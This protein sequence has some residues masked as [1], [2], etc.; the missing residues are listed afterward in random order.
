MKR[1]FLRFL[2]ALAVVL[3]TAPLAAQNTGNIAVNNNGDKPDQSAILDV[4]SNFGAGMQRG[5]LIPRLTTAQQTALGAPGVLPQ[6]LMIMNITTLNYEYIEYGGWKTM[7]RGANGWDLLGNNT[8]PSAN[9]FIGTRDNIDLSF[10]TTN[11]LR[12]TLKGTAGAR[13]LS[14]G[15]STAPAEQVDVN[16]GALRINK[17]SGVAPFS[18]GFSQGTIMYWNSSTGLPS[19][20]APPAPQN[21][22]TL[23]FRSHWGNINGANYVV[24]GALANSGGWSKLENDYQE[25]FAKPYT[26]QGTPVCSNQVAPAGA[27]IQRTTVPVYSNALAAAAQF[28]V[29]PFLHD[30]NQ[31]RWRQQFM[32][33]KGEL[34]VEYNQLNPVPGNAAIGGLCP[35]QP[36]NAISFWVNQATVAGNQRNWQYVIT[37]KHVAFGVNDLNAGFD[38]SIDP[39][40]GCSFGVSAQPLNGPAG[41]RTFNL[42]TPFVWDGFRN[43]VVEVAVASAPPATIFALLPVRYTN[44]GANLT[45]VAYGAP[46]YTAACQPAAGLA[47]SC[48]PANTATSILQTCNDNGGQAGTSTNRPVIL[49]SGTVSTAPAATTS[50]GNYLFYNGGFMV[51]SSTVTGPWARQT[52]PYFAYQGPGTISAVAGVYDNGTKLNDHVFDRAFDG[53]VKPADAAN[54][55]DQRNL[56]IPEMADYTRMNRHLPTMKGRDSWQAERGFSFGDL[57]NQLWTTTETQSLYLTELHDRLNVL[58]LLS[59]D[60]PLVPKELL[61]ARS[62]VCS[63]PQFTDADK[64]AVM[65]SLQQRTV[66]TEQH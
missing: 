22:D 34:N 57:T 66:T 58:E 43:V 32:F 21:K 65:K 2:P 9:D 26:Q 31:R 42:T 24:A 8:A 63:M 39:A 29:T 37:L 40:Q 35:G 38:N 4:S 6:G 44:T 27:E 52:V 7:D 60:R 61:L 33:L 20:Y 5:M 17:T 23:L 28:F 46:P 64:A 1:S 14:V 48:N 13:Y 30:L 59:D 49:F 56:G 25:R 51:D 12:M 36:V 16:G 41:W 50:T 15:P 11:T 45:R 3:S 10:R 47:G 53:T 54:F 18:N 55:G 19:T 62:S